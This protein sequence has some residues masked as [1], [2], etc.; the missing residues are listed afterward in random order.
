MTNPPKQSRPSTSETVSA[1][2]KIRMI[3]IKVVMK[4]EKK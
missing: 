4:A 1:C 2:A 3:E